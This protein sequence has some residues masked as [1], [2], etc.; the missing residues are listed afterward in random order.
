MGQSCGIKGCKTSKNL[1]S[2]RNETQF[3]QWKEK[4]K[5]KGNCMKGLKI[6]I[7]HFKPDDFEKSLSHDLGFTKRVLL[8]TDAIPSLFMDTSL[9]E[10]EVI[11]ENIEQQDA[12]VSLSI[13]D[14]LNV[15]G[16]DATTV[17]PGH[18][19]SENASYLIN[20][21]DIPVI[22]SNDVGTQCNFYNDL[23]NYV[24]N[25]KLTKN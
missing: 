6:C 23:L 7:R 17:P 20:L 21:K 8:K 14:T 1:K 22:L 15:V 4:L 18:V 10:Q 13:L 24:E 5:R 2:P 19:D 12:N 25:K 11:V 16:N 9:C 3:K